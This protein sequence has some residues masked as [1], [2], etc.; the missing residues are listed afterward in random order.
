MS[1]YD[2]NIS[3]VT[4]DTTAADA[5]ELATPLVDGPATGLIVGARI[6]GG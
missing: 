3:D 2:A 6:V 1:Q 5:C 4:R